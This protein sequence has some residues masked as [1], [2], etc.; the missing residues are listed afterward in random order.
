MV[1]GD[2]GA[3]VTPC[4]RCQGFVVN[5]ADNETPLAMCLNCGWRRYVPGLVQVEQPPARRPW[6]RRREKPLPEELQH[7]MYQQ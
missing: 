1:A 7:G 6:R 3:D 2:A 4:P 5:D